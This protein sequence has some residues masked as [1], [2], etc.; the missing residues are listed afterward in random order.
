MVH[1]AR[2]NMHTP[3]FQR[4]RE[5]YDFTQENLAEDETPRTWEEYW[6]AML[7]DREWPDNF[8]IQACAWYLQM[9]IVIVYAGHA[10]PEKPIHPIE[11]T[12]NSAKTGPT[13]LVGH[14]TMQ[15]YQS[16]LPLEEDRSLPTYLA[17]AAMNSTLEDV[18]NALGKAG[19]GSQVR[20]SGY[21]YFL[22]PFSYLYQC[23]KQTF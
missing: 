1:F 10:T 3:Q 4:M 21:C 16:L 20:K 19:A 17:P 6:Q 15:H 11:G 22:F 13:L 7:V 5:N 2:R 14:I 12:F 8:F 9:N 18:L 23:V